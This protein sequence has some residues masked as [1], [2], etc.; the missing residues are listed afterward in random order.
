MNLKPIAYPDDLQAL[1]KTK[2]TSPNL[3]NKTWEDDDLADLK[4]YIKSY[5]LKA[6]N[7]TCPYCLQQFK[8]NHG[9]Y[10]DIEHIISRDQTV[11]FMFEPLN[12]CMS[13][14]DCN[15]EKSNSKTTKSTAKV[16]YPKKSDMFT[17]VHPHLDVYTDN[18][19]PIEIGLFYYPK[20]SKGRKTIDNCGLNRFYEFAGYVSLDEAG[21]RISKLADLA[22]KTDDVEIKKSIFTEITSLTLRSLL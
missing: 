10:W 21:L 18:I 11:E 15:K 2:I 16:R 13:C 3:S 22:N 5:Y 1:I 8:S 14:I 7:H 17:I 6:Q 12:L 20:G 4:K 19:V 9:R